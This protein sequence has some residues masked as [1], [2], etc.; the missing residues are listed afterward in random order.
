LLVVPFVF[1]ACDA[2]APGYS[3]DTDSTSGVS[4]A[5]DQHLSGCHGHASSTIPADGMYVITTFG[6]G[7]DTQ[8]M[9]WGGTADGVGWY[10]ASRQ[11]YGCGAHLQIEANGKCVVVSAMDYGPDVCVENAAG[12]PIIDASPHVT[13]TL[14]GLSGAGWSDRIKVHVTEVDSS[15]PLGECTS[16]GG[17]GGGARRRLATPPPAPP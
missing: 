12:S 7:S 2:M 3:E 9:S 10:A 14:F 17:G 4:V 1:S 8:S 11:R 15:T 6:G 16:G 13:K 5:A